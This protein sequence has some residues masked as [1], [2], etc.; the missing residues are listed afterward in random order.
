MIFFST[1]VWVR[2]S[3]VIRGVKLSENAPFPFRNC[4]YCP[5]PV[6]HAGIAT[7]SCLMLL[8]LLDILILHGTL[9]SR[10]I[11]SFTPIIRILNCECSKFKLLRYP[12]SLSLPLAPPL[13]WWKLTISATRISSCVKYSCECSPF[14]FFL[15]IARKSIYTWDF[16]HEIFALHFCSAADVFCV[17]PTQFYFC[18]LNSAEVSY[19]CNKIR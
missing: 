15:L 8:V 17:G 1:M 12:L 14:I 16:E 9:V 5:G 3:D 13:A 6:V 10:T 11:G 19:P 18:M 2:V 7:L 4:T